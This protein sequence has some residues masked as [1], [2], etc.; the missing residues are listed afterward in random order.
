MRRVG[1]CLWEKRCSVH[2][3]QIGRNSRTIIAIITIHS[4][5]ESLLLVGGNTVMWF[6]NLQYSY[7]GILLCG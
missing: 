7:D 3:R 6:I 4:E 1:L 5:N 2:G